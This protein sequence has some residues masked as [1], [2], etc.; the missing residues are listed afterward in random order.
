MA[1]ALPAAE[2]PDQV[3]EPHCARPTV[4][5]NECVPLKCHPSKALLT[6]SM[7]QDPMYM[8]L[9]P[10]SPPALLSWPQ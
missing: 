3:S 7:I 4:T 5:R 9:P 6:S 1:A 8:S 2:D 10:G